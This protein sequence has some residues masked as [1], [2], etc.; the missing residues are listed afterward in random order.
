MKSAFFIIYLASAFSITLSQFLS[1]ARANIEPLLIKC[2]LRHWDLTVSWRFPFSA[3][4]DGF[5][6]EAQ[7]A[8]DKLLKQMN[9][10]LQLSLNTDNDESTTTFFLKSFHLQQANYAFIRAC[11]IDERQIEVK[12]NC[13][14]SIRYPIS[15]DAMEKS[16]SKYRLLRTT[17]HPEEAIFT[18]YSTDRKREIDATI[19][20]IGKG[21]YS[22]KLGKHEF[23]ALEWRTVIGSEDRLSL[24]GLRPDTEYSC[25]I[26]GR[27]SKSSQI[28]DIILNDVEFKTGKIDVPSPPAPKLNTHVV[29]LSTISET[30]A[31][32]MQPIEIQAE[33]SKYILIAYPVEPV[34]LP[35]GS[36]ANPNVEEVTSESLNSQIEAI[37]SIIAIPFI[38][39][40]FMPTEL[41]M[42]HSLVNTKTAAFKEGNCYYFVLAA[43]SSKQTDAIGWNSTVDCVLLGRT[44]LT[45]SQKFLRYGGFFAASSVICFLCLFT[46]I[47]I[48]SI[49]T[50]KKKLGV[51]GKTNY[52]KMRTVIPP[53]T[54]P[55]GEPIYEY[56]SPNSPPGID[57]DD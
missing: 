23:E 17:T 44:N 36:M 38:I 25:E 47:C 55:R 1:P 14:K 12:R 29:S 16:Y 57:D 26:L 46:A 37:S 43:E 42:M 34:D 3:Y 20:C 19:I 11:S 48:K 21:L 41:P 13:T 28:V 2:D 18:I 4:L 30:L 51:S 35:D 45:K 50:I 22:T 40:T 56:I 32:F 53:D 31:I 6:L 33:I 49:A 39:R 5:Y 15:K 7:F 24:S 9:P 27:E 52:T 54:P 8:E 10:H